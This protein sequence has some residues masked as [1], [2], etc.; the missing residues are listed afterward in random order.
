M[1][2]AEVLRL[3]AFTEVTDT[4]TEKMSGVNKV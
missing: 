1:S 2:F 3:K 4:E